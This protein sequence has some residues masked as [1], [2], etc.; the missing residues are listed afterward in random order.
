L[1]TMTL[2]DRLI[3]I[4]LFVAVLLLVINVI[5]SWQHLSVRGDI[6]QQIQDRLD[7]AQRQNEDLKKQLVQVESRQYIEQEARNKLNLGRGGEMIVLLPSI[8]PPAEP[9][10]TI[11]DT[12]A[13]WQ[14]WIRTFL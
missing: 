9:T 12:F 10:P 13:N 6:I 5:R 4:I 2:R 7:K 3:N 14:R 1:S 8:S 11:I